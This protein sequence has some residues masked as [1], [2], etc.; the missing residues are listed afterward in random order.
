MKST[1]L[2]AWDPSTIA[3]SSRSEALVTQ[4]I[5]DIHELKWFRHHDHGAPKPRQLKGE[6]AAKERAT[7]SALLLDVLAHSLCGGP[8]PLTIR[9]DNNWLS[10]SGPPAR[11]RTVNERVEMLHELEW[12]CV[13]YNEHVNRR[14]ITL[15]E[16]GPKLLEA[17]AK[18]GLTLSDIGSA[19]DTVSDVLELRGEKI[20][21]HQPR[22]SLKLPETEQVAALRAEMNLLN[23]VLQ[24]V[25][26]SSRPGT[27]A[28]VDIRRRHLCRVFFNGTLAHGGRTSGTAFWL[29]CPKM[30]R[31][32]SLLIEGEPIAEV[33][34]VAAVPSIVYAELGAVPADDPYNLPDLPQVDRDL[35]KIV[36]MQL[37]W[38]AYGP[39]FRLPP[40]VRTLIDSELTAATIVEAIRRHNEPIGE[41]LGNAS[42]AGP[43]L[44]RLESDII[45]RSA[46]KAHAAGISA[47]P[48]HDAL[49]VPRSQ[50]GAA[51]QCLKEAFHERLG[52]TPR[53]KTEKDWD[54]QNA[55]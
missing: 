12:L 24:D 30:V 41:V 46:L 15:L 23:A 45:I 3:C 55:A 34:I 38:T 44:Q 19:T 16:P 14:F 18:L 21:K 40:N 31:R 11:N 26:M 37:L 13:K 42:P 49:I 47:L 17:A 5:E 35:V 43:R 9:L 6:K 8:N 48:L 22:A 20:S 2:E 25:S 51:E 54:A 53:V 50:A 52:Q 10:R 27:L 28:P 29:S 1:T 33:D 4:A 32:S 39:K 36:V 7:V